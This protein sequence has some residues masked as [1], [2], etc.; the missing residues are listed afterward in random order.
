MGAN[1]VYREKNMKERGIIILNKEF[2]ENWLPLLREGGYN[3][4]GLH[5]L[6]P[7]GGME[8]HMNW[9]LK[10]Q[11]RELIDKFENAGI[12][13]EQELHSVDWL[14]PR[15]LFSCFPQWFRM[16]ESGERV[17]DWNFCVSNEEAL[18]YVELSAYKYA[19]LLRQKIGRAHV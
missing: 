1:F 6:Y 9:L 8:W 12:A 7:Y 19:L 18:E 16:N 13:V 2:N 10:K 3:K 15:S 11:T 4:L 5:S 14:L 17:G